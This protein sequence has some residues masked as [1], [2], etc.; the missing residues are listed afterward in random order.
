MRIRKQFLGSLLGGL[1]LAANSVDAQLVTITDATL[2]T[3]TRDGTLNAGEYGSLTYFSSGSGSGFGNVLFGSGGKLYWDSSL[4]GGLNFGVQLG[5]GG[6]ND[7]GVIYIDSVSG[8]LNNTTTIEDTGDS[9]R[10]AI[11]GDGG[12][13]QS[14]LTFAAGFNADYAIT[15]E[16]GFSGLFKINGDGSLTFQTSL[17]LTPTGSGPQQREGELLLS[18]IGLST[19]GSFK[20]VGTYLNSGN[21]YRSDELNGQGTAPGGNIGQSPFTFDNYNTFNSV[22]EPASAAL[23][24]LGLLAGAFWVR[25][26][27]A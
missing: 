24:G 17:Q 26:P 27:R 3:S 11:S 18:D 1:I 14:E 6:L 2:G 10:S 23:L 19:G 13:N 4:G 22:P 8:G 5:G 20:Y 7:A 25:R 21:A 15:I 16:N 9:G 12:G